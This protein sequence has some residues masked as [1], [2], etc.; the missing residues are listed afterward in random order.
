MKKDAILKAV[1]AGKAPQIGAVQIH[2]GRFAVRAMALNTAELL[3]L[4]CAVQRALKVGTGAGDYPDANQR[5][6]LGLLERRLQKAMRG[7]TLR[8]PICV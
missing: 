8:G 6:G 2:G 4:W 1:R 3:R 5:R 7:G